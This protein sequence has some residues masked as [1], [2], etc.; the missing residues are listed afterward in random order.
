MMLATSKARMIW[1]LLSL[2]VGD[3]IVDDRPWMLGIQP[4]VAEPSRNTLRW[5]LEGQSEGGPH[6]HRPAVDPVPVLLPRRLLIELRTALA[7][8]D[9]GET[10]DIVRPAVTGRHD[11]AW[12]WDQM[13]ATAL[14]HVAFL[15]GQGLTKQIARQRVAARMDIPPNSLRD[16]ER[17]PQL[18]LNYATAFDAG[19]LK[20]ILDDNPKH[21]EGDGKTVDSGA[22]AR[23]HQFRSDPPLADFGQT[24]KERFGRRH[25]PG[26]TAGN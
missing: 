1:Q 3:W 26:G 13:R 9:E 8:L 25:N 4:D 19:N 23:L 11:D 17:T 15:H 14:E 24:Y 12:T 5:N 22:L 2:E 10:H 21:A 7:A 6:P 16:W 18:M 20:T